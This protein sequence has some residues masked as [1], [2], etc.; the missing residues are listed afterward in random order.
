MGLF[1]LTLCRLAKKKKFAHWQQSAAQYEKYHQ[2][3]QMLTSSIQQ[4][5]V[6]QKLLRVHFVSAFKLLGT[7]YKEEMQLIHTEADAMTMTEPNASANTWRNTPRIFICEELALCE[8]DCWHLPS[9]FLSELSKEDGAGGTGGWK[10]SS[11][12]LSSVATRCVSRVRL[13]E[14]P[15][16]EW[17]CVWPCSASKNETTIQECTGQTDT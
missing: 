17:L 3:L 6:H 16:W 12:S 2:N 15:P 5:C 14:N 9:L 13:R 7:S 8:C 11:F 4:R 10:V 1:L